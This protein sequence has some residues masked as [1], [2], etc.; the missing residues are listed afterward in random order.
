VTAVTAALINPAYAKE[1]LK[2]D[3]AAGPVR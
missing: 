3:Q 2:R 1:A